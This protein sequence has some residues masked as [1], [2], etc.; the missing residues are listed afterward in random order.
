MRLNVVFFTLALLLSVADAVTTWHVVSSGVGYETNV[1]I[2]WAAKNVEFYF[3]K[4]IITAMMLYGIASICNGYERLKIVSF[5][6]IALF[7]SI[8][9]LNN[10]MAIVAGTDLNLNLAKQFAL[11]A[12]VFVLSNAVLRIKQT[13]ERSTLSG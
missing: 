9:V 11:F 10:I 6:S 13:K 7:Y 4:V 1:A 3:L 8:I 5:I 12:V 2:A